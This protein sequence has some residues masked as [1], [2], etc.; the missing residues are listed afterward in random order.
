M[1]STFLSRGDRQNALDVQ[2]GLHRTLVSGKR[3]GLVG[4]ETVQADAVRLGVNRDRPQPQFGCRPHDTN[5]DLAAVGSQKFVHRLSGTNEKRVIHEGTRRTTKG[6]QARRFCRI[7]RGCGPASR[8]VTPREAGVTGGGATRERGRPARMHSRCVPL[9]FPAMPHPAT[10]PAGTARARPKQSP[11]AVAGLAGCRSW[12]RPC[13]CCAGGTPAFPGGHPLVAY[14]L[15]V[16]F[17]SPFG[18]LVSLS[19]DPPGGAGAALV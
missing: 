13:Q 15:L 9:S 11:G 8:R 3:I 10:L 5:G 4:L 18:S 12:V 19:D 16:L 7:G 1:A 6:H 2:I 14:R 17:M